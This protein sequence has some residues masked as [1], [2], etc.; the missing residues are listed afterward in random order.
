MAGAAD[1]EE[2][3]VLALELDLLVVEPARQEDVPIGGYEI[4][5]LEPLVPAGSNLGRHRRGNIPA[6]PLRPDDDGNQESSRVREEPMP[7]TS[8][9]RTR[10]VPTKKASG[11]PRGRKPAPAE[12]MTTWNSR[13]RARC[14]SNGSSR[15][16]LCSSMAMAEQLPI[17][18]LVFPGFLPHPEPPDLASVDPAFD[19]SEEIQKLKRQKRALVLAHYYQE[20]EIQDLAD[21]VGDSLDLSRKAQQADANIIAFAGVRFM[22]ETAKIT[23]NPLRKVVLPDYEARVFC[24]RAPARRRPSAPGAS[25]TPERS[26]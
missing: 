18:P 8:R 22:A 21:F 3:P 23:L 15:L 5:G 13:R 10:S 2:D 17:N 11:K 7:Q 9:P 25:S 19:L 4:P 14:E 6:D 20:E 1:L 12:L 16:L 26:A 24:S